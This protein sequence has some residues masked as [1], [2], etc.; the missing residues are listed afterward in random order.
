[1]RCAP[2]PPTVRLDRQEDSAALSPVG[3]VQ[4]YYSNRWG[5]ICDSD[6]DNAGAQVLCHQLGY[7]SGTAFTCHLFGRRTSYYRL[8]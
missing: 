6:W 5:F 2:P 3:A 8:V 4:A 7:S 1:M